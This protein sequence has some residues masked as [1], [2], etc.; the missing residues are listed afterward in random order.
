MKRNAVAWA[1][2]VVS[3]AALFSSRGLTRVVPAAPG[4]PAESRKAAEALSE[5]FEAVADYVRPSVVQISVQRKAGALFRNRGRALPFPG[6][7]GRT[8]D[9]K[10]FEEMLKRFF[11][12]DARPENEQFG[13]PMAEGTGSGFIYDDRGHI[14]TNN[15]VVDGAQ[16]LTVKF[17]D[18]IEATA[19]VVGTDSQTD[20]AVIK[21][22]TTSYRPLPKGVSSKLRVGQLVMAVGSPFGLSES[23]TTGIISATERNNVGINSFE[24]FLQTD[25]PI[26]PGNSGGP[27]VD[28]DGRVVGMNSAIVTGGRGNDGVG[29][30]IPIDMAG[31][32][33]DKL[34]KEGKVRRARVGIVI[35]VLTPAMAK[36]LGLEAQTKGILI[37][38]VVK[39]S[40]AEK[41]GLRQGDVLTTFNGKPVVSL[42]AFRLEVASS[43]IGKS[44]GLTYIRDGKEHTTTIVPAPSEQVVFDQEKDSSTPRPEARPEPAKSAID[45]FGLEVQPLTPDLAAQFGLPRET[46]GLLVSSV[47]EGSPAEAAN[48]EA[49]DVITKVIKDRKITPV[50]SVRDLKDV[51]AQSNDL[52]LFVQSRRGPRGFV[53]L[54]KPAKN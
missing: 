3:A 25:A 34:I 35:G 30:A 24:S 18:G 51:A 27:L 16:K 8:P 17:H 41:A 32:V 49:G 19:T 6:P 22:D 10:D 38:E 7:G 39:G 26:N 29:F 21:V 53:T 31:T 47:K 13:G 42:P 23:V 20:I 45:D 1:A 46:T 14:L 9:M 44:F 54:S 36:Q 12:P 11:G 2:L 5:A 4:I 48:I 28:M 43:D 33:A 40:P 37:S 15:H 50:K 52:A